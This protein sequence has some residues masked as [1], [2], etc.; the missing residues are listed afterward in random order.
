MS[1]SIDQ[2]LAV[3]G[4]KLSEQESKLLQ[5]QWERILALKR[6]FDVVSHNP[7]DIILCYGAKG[8]NE[9]E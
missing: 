1:I 9:H 6:D 2:L 4:I 7:E 5:L 8:G 3:K